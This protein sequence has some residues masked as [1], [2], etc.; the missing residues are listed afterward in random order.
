MAEIAGH[1]K[2]S[3]GSRSLLLKHLNHQALELGIDPESSREATKIFLSK[4]MTCCTDSSL[5][6]LANSRHVINTS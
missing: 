2:G 3:K 1:R 6:D 4:R 5:Q